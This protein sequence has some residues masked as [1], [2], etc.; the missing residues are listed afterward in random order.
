MTGHDPARSRRPVHSRALN[1][2]RDQRVDRRSQSLRNL[3][4]VIVIGVQEWSPGSIAT[5]SHQA[6][7]SMAIDA[8]NPCRKFFPP[9]GPISPAQLNP[10]SGR[11]PS[12]LETSDAS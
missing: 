9:I 3:E 6:S 2:S 11:P 12:F 8:V 4:K 10:A 1:A 5:W 7:T